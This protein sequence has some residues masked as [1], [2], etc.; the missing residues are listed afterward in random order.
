MSHDIFRKILADHKELSSL[1]QVLTEIINVANNP[2]SSVNN[3]ADVVKKD[4]GLTVRLLRVVN[5]LYYSPAAE[6]KTVK[7]A[8]VSLGVRTVTAIALSSSVY[9][10]VNKVSS[11]I[12]PKKFWRHSLEVAL[13]ARMIAGRAGFEPAEEAFVAGLLHDIGSLILEASFRDRYISVW[14]EVES[15]ES[16][17]KL[18][19]K[20]L[21]TNHARV[22]QFLLKQWKIP[23]EICN[24]VGQHH[25]YLTAETAA[26]APQLTL[27]VALANR[28]SKFKLYNMPPL[29]EFMLRQRKVLIE[30]L[31]LSQ[32]ELGE[33]ERNLVGEVISE[34]EFLEINVGGLEEILAEANELLYRQYLAAE[35][36][37]DQRKDNYSISSE[38]Q[39][40][41]PSGK[42]LENLIRQIQRIIAYLKDELNGRKDAVEYDSETNDTVSV[43]LTISL[44]ALSLVANELEILSN[45]LEHPD[46]I[47]HRL[48]SVGLEVSTLLGEGKKLSQKIRV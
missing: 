26:S 20:Y 2:D 31:R 37:L 19:E 11:H 14:K 12:D 1:P 3:L 33:I 42:I 48:E 5:S 46:N 9:S 16:I 36:L 10:L 39:P 4:P 29:D 13:A 43:K 35:K 40:D 7:Q 41:G 21:S 22:G 15:G 24:A 6:I 44:K 18:E 30:N 23:D 8:V 45:G 27:I 17:T 38:L 25:E 32:K 28:I 34:S 47:S